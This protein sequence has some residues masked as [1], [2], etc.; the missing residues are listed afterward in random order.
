METQIAGVHSKCYLAF[1]ELILALEAP[2][3]DFGGQ[4]PI[5]EV[6]DEFDK[7]KI[8]AGNVGAA[9]EGKTSQLSLDY[10]LREA[11]FYKAQVCLPLVD[12][13]NC[14]VLLRGMMG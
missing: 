7:Y 8:W 11:S 12:R 2:T 13:L 10:R 4:I 5:L 14:A 6:Q 1:D 3:R 9:H